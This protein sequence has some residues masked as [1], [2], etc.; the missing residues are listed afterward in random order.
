MLRIIAAQLWCPVKMGQEH[1]TLQL[2]YYH[3]SLFFLLL[4]GCVLGAFV[5]GW[6]GKGGRDARV[7]FCKG[8]ALYTLT[9][10]RSTKPNS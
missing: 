3:H 8:M 2:F 5:R 4:F 7:G 10:R 6:E 9:F 1:F